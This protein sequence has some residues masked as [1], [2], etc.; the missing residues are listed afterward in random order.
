MDRAMPFQ[1]GA[2]GDAKPLRLSVECGGDMTRVSYWLAC[3][4]SFNDFTAFAERV[5]RIVQAV[6]ST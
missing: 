5:G 4:V 1:F 6:K 2:P 3:L